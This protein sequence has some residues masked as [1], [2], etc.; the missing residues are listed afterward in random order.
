MLKK[1]G[2]S[3]CLLAKVH[4]NARNISKAMQND[5]VSFEVSPDNDE[6]NDEVS[7]D[8]VDLDEQVRELSGYSIRCHAHTL[9]LVVQKCLKEEE[10]QALLFK[11]RKIVGHFR[12]STSMAAI[13]EDHQ[14]KDGKLVPLRLI[15]EVQTRWNST[16]KMVERLCLLRKYIETVIVETKDKILE[17]HQLIATEWKSLNHSR[18]P[19]IFFPSN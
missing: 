5:D 12:S 7:A 17:S 15:Q 13:L 14:K 6:P 3:G 2:F 16:F 11:V 19:E 10:L 9:N 4:D 8:N 1:L 18:S